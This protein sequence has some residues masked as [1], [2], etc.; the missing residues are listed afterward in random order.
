MFSNGISLDVQTSLK[1]SSQT[2]YWMINTEENN[3][4]VTLLLFNFTCPLTVLSSLCFNGMSM[5]S[6]TRVYESLLVCTSFFAFFSCFMFVL[7]YTMA[8]NFFYFVLFHIIAIIS[9]FIFCD[10]RVRERGFGW[11]EK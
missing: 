2:Q 9:L 11:V 10:E 1:G 5:C 7:L 4:F 8:Y 6:N 3:G